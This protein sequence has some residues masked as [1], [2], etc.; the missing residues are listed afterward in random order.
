[1]KMRSVR[2]FVP[3]F[4]VLSVQSVVGATR[5]V[6]QSGQTVGLCADWGT[7]CTLPFALSIAQSGDQLWV[8]AG[9]Y[10]SI[11]S[12]T[13]PNGV[14]LIGGFAG[15]ES[16]ASQSNATANVTILDGGGTSQ[17]LSS[18]GHGALNVIRGFTI[19]NGFNSSNDGG[20]AVEV[21][22]SGA[23]FVQCIFEN[24][25]ADY[26]G[27]AIAI[28]GASSPQFINCLFRGNGTGDGIAAKPFGGGAVYLYGGTATFTNCLFHGNRAGDGGAVFMVFGTASF[29]NCTLADNSAQIGYG[30]AVVDPEGRATF[31][32]SILWGNTAARGAPQIATG[33]SAQSVITYSDVQGGWTG[34]GNLDWNPQFFPGY[35]IHSTSPCKNSGYNKWVPSDAGDIDWDGQL[36]EKMPQDLAGSARIRLVTVDMGA[37]ELFN[38]PPPGG[39]DQ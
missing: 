35:A 19:R 38:D 12:E 37:F 26:F 34:V 14:K 1:M 22:D 24:N 15:T 27:A 23:L 16:N 30:G 6:E 8:K 10:G 13:W 7:A 9:N 4:S 25:R 28:R 21:I 20:G 2:A 18:S 32:N 11:A 5:F 29:H 39:E 31:N 33:T 17:C 3:L 36:G